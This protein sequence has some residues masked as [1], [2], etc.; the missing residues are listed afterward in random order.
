[1]P[2]VEDEEFE[3]L[4][5]SANVRQPGSGP[6]GKPNLKIAKVTFFIIPRHV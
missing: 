4:P 5:S 2:K 6:S 3:G 1:M